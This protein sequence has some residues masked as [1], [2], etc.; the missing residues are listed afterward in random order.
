MKRNKNWQK[1]SC[2][3][4]QTVIFQQYMWNRTEWNKIMFW[5]QFNSVRYSTLVVHC[6]LTA[7]MW[8]AFISCWQQIDLYK[9]KTVSQSWKRVNEFFQYAEYN[10]IKALLLLFILQ[11]ICLVNACDGCMQFT[12]STLI[13]EVISMIQP[14]SHTGS[15]YHIVACKPIGWQQ[16]RKNN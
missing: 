16:P 7:H 11:T 14:F 4:F 3:L 12:I 2:H 9:R 1:L 10:I 5:R 15:D 13:R 8:A 6:W